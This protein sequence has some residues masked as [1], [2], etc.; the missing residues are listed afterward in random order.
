[1]NETSINFAL[2]WRL[3]RSRWVVL[4][5]L[6]V[7]GAGLGA[8]LSTVLSPGY[9]S[10]A[11]VL[12]QS[13]SSSEDAVTGET[14]IATSLVVLDR[15]ASELPG[16][17]TGRQ[18][19]DRVTAEIADGNVLVINGAGPTPEE[20]QQ[21]T[22]KVTNGYVGF[23]AQIIADT[24]KA[25][26]SSTQQART[27]I[28]QKIDD[29]NKR[30][31]AIQASP[32]VSAIGPVGDQARSDLQQQQRIVGDATKDL[33]QLDS[34]A[35]TA[36]LTATLRGANARVI[37][38][39]TLPVAVAPPTP[40]QLVLIGLAALV[41]LGVFGHLVAMRTDRRL[42]RAQDMAAAVGAPVLGIVGVN[43]TS[44]PSKPSFLRRTLFDDRRWVSPS[45]TVLDTDRARDVRYQRLLH[46]LTPDDRPVV[47]L[48]VVPEGDEMALNAVIDLG[49]VAAAGGA[50]VALV[51]EAEAVIA[52]VTDAAER[53]GVESQLTA[54]PDAQSAAASLTILLVKVAATQP[55]MPETEATDAAILL[56]EVGTRTGWELAGIAGA[57]VDAGQPLL[58]LVTVVPAEHPR[59]D[60]STGLTSLESESATMA[61]HA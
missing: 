60:E 12:L 58:G 47:I 61:G 29:A 11:K 17:L 7:V 21:L 38:L 46:R 49:L 3:V 52:R 32:A 5:L 50:T 48:A 44:V 45:L 37:Q 34:A 33:E 39:A 8:A 14:Q 1:M 22:D 27:A 55:T 15:V 54:G 41:L 28:Q 35:E 53:R 40:L 51:T 23:A 2:I 9:V 18:L 31:T 42:R 20:A 6:A 57:C 26:A 59:T 56:V 36:A 19:A 13:S 24:T 30:I 25:T 4:T 10:T 43:P 16:G